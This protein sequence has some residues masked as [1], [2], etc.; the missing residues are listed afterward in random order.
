MGLIQSTAPK[1]RDMKLVADSCDAACNHWLRVPLH[2]HERC[3]Q[4]KASDHKARSASPVLAPSQ[5]SAFCA[6]C[7]SLPPWASVAQIRNV[8][9]QKPFPHPR[10]ANPGAECCPVRPHQIQHKRQHPLQRVV[11]RPDTHPPHRESPP[12]P[13]NGHL[14]ESFRKPC[15]PRKERPCVTSH[16]RLIVTGIDI[17]CDFSSDPSC[18]R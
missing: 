12:P 2:S 7:S 6:R 10:L 3:R 11:A 8:S 18:D 16:V 5:C 1:H 14:P 9:L 13:K 17:D 15:L 4:S